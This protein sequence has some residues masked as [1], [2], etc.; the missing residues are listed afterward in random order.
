MGDKSNCFSQMAIGVAVDFA[1]NLQ[2]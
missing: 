2:F 1:G